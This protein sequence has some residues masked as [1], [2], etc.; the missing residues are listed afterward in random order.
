[1]LIS[2]L[3]AAN[4]LFVKLFVGPA[5]GTHA[6]SA[7]PWGRF[8]TLPLAAILP[9]TQTAV[10]RCEP[11]HGA[12]PPTATMGKRRW[13]PSAIRTPSQWATDVLSDPAASTAQCMPLT[14]C[15]R[16]GPVVTGFCRPAFPNFRPHAVA[17]STDL[18][19][20]FY[21]G[22]GWWSASSMPSLRA[23]THVAWHDWLF[24]CLAAT[25]IVQCLGGPT[26]DMGPNSHGG[27]GCVLL[28]PARSAARGVGRR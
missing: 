13:A 5:K 2:T 17:P 11:A 22:S 16:R 4:K 21:S 19:F 20:N 8:E 10:I 9:N 3:G 6:K 23:R 24:R 25:I 1:M 18:R 26:G 14:L 7:W 12:G 15:K 28:A 27:V